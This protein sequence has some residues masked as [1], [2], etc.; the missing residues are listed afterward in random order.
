[1]VAFVVLFQ[2]EEHEDDTK[3]TKGEKGALF[4]V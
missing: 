4:R 3:V 2:H 1:L